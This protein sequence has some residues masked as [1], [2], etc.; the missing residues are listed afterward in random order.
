VVIVTNQAGI[1]RGYY[2][3][4][5]FLRLTEWMIETFA[6]HHVRIARVYYCPYHPVHGLGRYKCESADR[7][8]G[9]GMILRAQAD[10]DLDLAASVLVGDRRSDIDAARAAGVG[11]SI[12]LRPDAA[13]PSTHDDA[14]HTSHSLDDIRSRFFASPRGGDR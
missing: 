8:P 6:E 13:E 1:A 4:A 7:K 10:F 14:C 3:E 11:T 2:T 9:P 12:L 5:D